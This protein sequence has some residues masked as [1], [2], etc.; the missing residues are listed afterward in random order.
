MYLLH[1]FTRRLRVFIGKEKLE[2]D[3]AEEM[4]FHLDERTAD[5]LA[6]GLPPDE[7]RYVAQRRFGNLG[8]IQETARDQRG[9]T[10]LENS[11]RDGRFA[12]RQLAKSPSFTAVAVLT[13]ALGIGANSAIFS[14]INSALLKPLPYPHADQLV[15]VMETQPDGRPN[16]SVSGGA[17][18]VCSPRRLRRHP[19]ESDRDRRPGTDNRIAGLRWVSF[20][21]R[22]R[23]SDWPRL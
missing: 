2:R 1:R 16:G 7:A 19:P 13:L 22:N 20:G 9:W 18:K 14:V 21:A 10:E 6:D 12:C 15:D 11:L 3:M 8:L 5:N 4:R 17:F 23:T